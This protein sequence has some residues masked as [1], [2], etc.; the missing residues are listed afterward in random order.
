MRLRVLRESRDDEENEE[1]RVLRR[2]AANTKFE[3]HCR[4]TDASVHW[5]S[6]LLGRQLQPRT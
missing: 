6:S 1:V 3:S 2:D 4:P 5:Q